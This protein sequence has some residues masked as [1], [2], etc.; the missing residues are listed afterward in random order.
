M[1][2][3]LLFAPSAA[4]EL[5]RGGGSVPALRRGANGQIEVAPTNAAPSKAP[6]RPR[7]A[8]R[9]SAPAVEPSGKA[10]EVGA[11]DKPQTPRPVI[12]V[13]PTVPRISDKTPLGAIVASYSVVMSDGSPFTGTVRF[14]AP[15]YDGQKLFALSDNKI[16]VNPNGPGVR[17]GKT[18]VTHHITLE[19]IP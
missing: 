19:T 4:Q 3:A 8:D 1:A 12:M 14:G 2:L 11:A 17:S 15:H 10:S 13:T 16:I 6:A 18:T 7:R 9:G 5:P